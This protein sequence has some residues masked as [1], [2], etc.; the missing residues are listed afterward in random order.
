MPFVRL[1][2][3][4]LV[5]NAG[6]LG[7]PYGQ[8]GAQWAHLA[9]GAATLRCT[10]YDVEAARRAIRE[11]CSFPDI[12]EWT[13]EYLYSRNSDFEALAAFGPMDGRESRG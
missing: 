3:R 5:V 8:V 9:E 2:N 6:S 12:D 1:V 7:M 4:R 11:S 13:D 10:T